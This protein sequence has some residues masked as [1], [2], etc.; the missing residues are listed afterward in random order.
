MRRGLLPQLVDTVDRVGQ[1]GEELIDHTFRQGVVLI[2]IW[3]V[4][5]VL[6]RLAH[7]VLGKR[8]FG[9]T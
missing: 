6:A 3:F 7:Q 9:T 1:E 5:Y 2:L 8:F 4:V